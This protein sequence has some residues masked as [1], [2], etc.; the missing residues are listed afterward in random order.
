MHVHLALCENKLLVNGKFETRC[1]LWS[2][3]ILV[4][5]SS[6]FLSASQDL[7]LPTLLKFI[8]IS[9]VILVHNCFIFW[10]ITFNLVRVLIGFPVSCLWTVLTQLLMN[11]GHAHTFKA[12]IKCCFP[13]LPDHKSGS[14]PW[15]WVPFP[16]FLLMNEFSLPLHDVQCS[17]M[18]ILG[19]VRS[20]GL[21]QIN[22]MVCSHSL[23]ALE[24]NSGES[25]EW[26]IQSGC[27]H[28]TCENAG[29][30]D[31]TV[32]LWKSHLACVLSF[33]QTS[34]TYF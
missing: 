21:N 17:I 22:V 15:G 30:S 5:V 19:S 9:H 18:S 7:S 4:S 27:M 2:P 24:V 32:N 33:H 8:Q 11:P 29:H 16:T 20:G 34:S 3:W 14:R 31:S 10:I 26:G 1:T 28:H 6:F 23:K 13:W 12:L 25:G